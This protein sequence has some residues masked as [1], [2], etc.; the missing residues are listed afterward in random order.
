MYEIY[1]TMPQSLVYAIKYL[2]NYKPTF[3]K[4]SAGNPC[5][6]DYFIAHRMHDA[7]FDTF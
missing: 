5:L 1:P 2:R 7:G 4:K 3:R 6:D